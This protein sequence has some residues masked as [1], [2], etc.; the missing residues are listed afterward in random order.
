MLELTTRQQQI[1]ELIQQPISADEICAEL[2]ISKRTLE[3]HLRDIANRLGMRSANRTLMA[4][5]LI[6]RQTDHTHVW[7]VWKQCTLCQAVDHVLR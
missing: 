2:H 5:T 6:R 1:V 4:L 7:R 3:N